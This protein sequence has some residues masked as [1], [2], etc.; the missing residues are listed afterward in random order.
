LLHRCPDANATAKLVHTYKEWVT[1]GGLE[2]Q[3]GIGLTTEH[4]CN[5]MSFVNNGA[6]CSFSA[7]SLGCSPTPPLAVDGSDSGTQCVNLV[8]TPDSGTQCVNLVMTPKPVMEPGGSLTERVFMSE[9][10]GI[11]SDLQ[12]WKWSLEF[13]SVFCLWISITTFWSFELLKGLLH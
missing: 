12:T 5:A 10:A 2:I 13:L 7:N 11:F 4:F 6:G 1:P 3:A 8:M 9:K